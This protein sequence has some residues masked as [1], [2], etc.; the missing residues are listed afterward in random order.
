MTTLQHQMNP[1]VQSISQETPWVQ[2]FP[3]SQT[4]IQSQTSPFN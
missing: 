4:K 1:K 3:N 2:I